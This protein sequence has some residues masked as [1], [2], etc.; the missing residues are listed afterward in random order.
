MSSFRDSNILGEN[1]YL[2]IISEEIFFRSRNEVHAATI[3]QKCLQARKLTWCQESHGRHGRKTQWQ[4]SFSL[5]PIADVLCMNEI[6]ER[7]NGPG[8]TD[9]DA[10]KQS[11][12]TLASPIA[13][14]ATA[15]K[16]RR[17]WGEWSVKDSL[18]HLIRLTSVQTTSSFP[19]WQAQHSETGHLP[20]IMTFSRHWKE[21][22][23]PF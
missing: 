19:G 14:F 15:E 21:L 5:G 3:H 9:M 17:K 2:C 1:G 10:G 12:W 6:L 18:I 13:E 11:G 22:Q 20:T 7:I 4:K 16:Y 23:N 8:I